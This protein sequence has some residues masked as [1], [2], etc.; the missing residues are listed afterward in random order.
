MLSIASVLQGILTVRRRGVD[1][2]NLYILL[3]RTKYI[4]PYWP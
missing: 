2:W 3:D 4:L 1:V